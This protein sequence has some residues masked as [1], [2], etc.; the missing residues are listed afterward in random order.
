[1][2]KQLVR[3]KLKV[4]ALKDQPVDDK[5]FSDSLSG[6]LILLSSYLITSELPYRFDPAA[7]RLFDYEPFAKAYLPLNVKTPFPQI[8]GQVLDSRDQD[9]F[10]ELFADGSA[11]ARLFSLA[12]SGATAADGSRKLFPT[13][14]RARTTRCRAKASYRSI[15]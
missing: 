1:M 15:R 4:K 13:T 6:F 8:F 5:T 2:K 7:G 11:R 9:I 10:R 12:R 14:S 3:S